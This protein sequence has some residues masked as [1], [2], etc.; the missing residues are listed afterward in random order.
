MN[1]MLSMV[2]SWCVVGADG[3]VVLW[4]KL[5]QDPATSNMEES[6]IS[7]QRSAVVRMLSCFWYSS[8]EPVL[9]TVFVTLYKHCLSTLIMTLLWNCYCGVGLILGID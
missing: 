7:M 1:T 9:F 8:W 2:W 3:P 4:Q 5:F 6:R